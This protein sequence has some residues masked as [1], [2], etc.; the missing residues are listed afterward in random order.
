MQNTFK[1]SNCLI[2][3]SEIENPTSELKLLSYYFKWNLYLN[4]FV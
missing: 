4:F 1:Y 2:F 3:N